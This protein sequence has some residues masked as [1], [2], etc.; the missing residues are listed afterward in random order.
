[1]I[2]IGGE[3]VGRVKVEALRRRIGYAIQSIGLFPHWIGRRQH[4]DRAAAVEVAGGAGPAAR[5]RAAR[6][7]PPRPGQISRQ[8]SAS[9]LG[10]RAAAGRGRPGARRRSGSIADGRA[11]CRRRPDHPRRLAG[12]TRAYPAGDAKDDRV[13]DPR[14]RRGVAPCHPDRDPQR[15]PH[16][17]VRP[18]ARD[19][20]TSGKRFC[21]AISSGI[22]VSGSSFCR[23]ARSRTGCG[24][25]RTP[26][27]SR[28]RTMPRCAR[29]CR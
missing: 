4:R 25:A 24:M 17:S 12:G 19:S 6:A 28:C 8:I 11:V 14:Y 26:M 1:M 13:R 22:K 18:A 16:R 21:R 7:V 5:R 10:R 20:R 27:A 23:C 29:H 15:G 3:D 9:A 2:R